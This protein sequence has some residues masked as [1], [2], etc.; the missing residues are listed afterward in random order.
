MVDLKE[1]F[2]PMERAL[3]FDNEIRTKNIRQL[4]YRIRRKIEYALDQIVAAAT[5][6]EIRDYKLVIAYLKGLKHI[7]REYELNKYESIID[8]IIK[9]IILKK[10]N[11]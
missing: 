1:L 2:S 5:H 8:E 3:I 7:L 9:E 10:E 6:P 11:V 4:R